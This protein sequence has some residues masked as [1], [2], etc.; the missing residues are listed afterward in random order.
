MPAVPPQ[1]LADALS[2]LPESLRRLAE[3][4]EARLYDRHRILI[5]EGDLGDTLY[6]ILSGQL[7]AY[8]RS[9]D[10]KEI[11]YGIYGPGEYIGEMSLDG[12]RRSAS[13][14]TLQRSLCTVITRRTLE[15]H[16]AEHP[17]FAFELLAKVIH[18][19][20]L[21]TVRARQLSL[22]HAQDRLLA[23][24]DAVAVPQRDG[25]RV[26]FPCPSHAGM[27]QELGCSRSMVSTLLKTLSDGG[28][29]RVEPKVLTVLRPL[30]PR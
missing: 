18:R 29:L 28:Y 24:I 8:A 16:I 30:P 4:G 20:R 3:R 27:S 10:D 14:I 11:T 15:A 12:G 22:T 25:T 23:W 17:A 26:V 7:R 19:A 13:V 9:E 2:R 1:V 5:E 21:M 6:I